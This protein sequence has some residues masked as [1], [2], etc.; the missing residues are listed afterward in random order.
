MIQLSFNHLVYPARGGALDDPAVAD[1]LRRRRACVG[2]PLA[3][4]ACRSS[5]VLRW[6]ASGYIQLIQGTPLLILLFLSYFGLGILGYKLDPLVAAGISLTIYA[7]GLPRRDLAR[8]HRG[9]ADAP[10][11]R[12]PI[13][14]ASTRFQQ[15]AYVILP[16]ALR[17]AI[18]PTV[19]FMVQIVKNTSLASVIGFVELARAGQIVNNS[20]FEPFVV[21]TCVAAIYFALC[22]PLSVAAA[23]WKGGRMPARVRSAPTALSPS[24]MRRQRRQGVSARCACSTASA[25]DVTRGQIV[26][27]IGRSGSGK[28]TLL[29]CID[30]LETMQGGEITVCGHAS[31]R[32]GSARARPAAPRRRH[33]VPE[34]QS[35]SASRRSSGTSRW[36]ST[37]VKKQA[38][39]RGE[40]AWPPRCWRMVGLTDKIDAYPEQLS[41]GQQQR[42]AIARSLA[43][44]P[45]VMLFDEVTSALDPELTAEVLG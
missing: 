31:S 9:G 11:G 22:Y 20:T 40:E 39:G 45:Q 7:G 10:S 33:G 30:R 23:R 38:E 16:Q 19:G 18:P 28:S 2:L 24:V 26:A 1:R 17:I 35:V 41:G 6:L 25:F 21:F 29:R 27:I 12:P 32:P 42:V 43:M 15:Y 3:L 13:A 4:C 14:W 36:R 37:L 5:R 44:Q 8:L 34:L